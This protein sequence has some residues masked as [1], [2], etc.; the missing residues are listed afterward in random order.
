MK[1][2]QDNAVTRVYAWRDL[3]IRIEW[4]TKDVCYSGETILQYH[5]VFRTTEKEGR[6]D[7]RL[8]FLED[9]APEMDLGAAR[10]V[11][12]HV[13]GMTI[14]AD[15]HLVYLRMRHSLAVI[16]RLAGS[17]TAFLAPN[18]SA[19]AS[20]LDTELFLFATFGL[21]ALMQA[22]GLYPLHAGALRSPGGTGML[23]VAESDSGKSTITLSLARQ[24]WSYLSDDSIILEQVEP[25]AQ[26]QASPFRRDFGVDPEAAEY[27]PEIS[28]RSVQQLTD[29]SKWRLDP[30]TI[31][32]GGR[33]E[34]CVPGIIIFPQIVDQH[35]SELATVKPAEAL[36]ELMKQSSFLTF[37]AESTSDYLTLLRRLVS[38]CQCVRLLAGRDLKADPGRVLPVL[39][40][41]FPFLAD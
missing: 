40:D 6:T 8:Q 22:R 16:D 39:L 41:R 9:L 32:V 10:E 11:T 35:T 2:E 5:G 24:G 12:R 25:D 1:D 37:D 33:V 38:G 30:D 29:A 21:V 19:L 27:F 13:S 7:W 14:L 23:L 26:L 17:M 31:Y 36:M 18:R 4:P 15:G 20:G 3:N 28:G 34:S